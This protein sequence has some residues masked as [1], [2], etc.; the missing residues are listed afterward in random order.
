M[1][2][3]KSYQLES[4]INFLELHFLFRKFFHPRSFENF[5]FKF[6]KFK[7]NFAWQDDFESKS[8]QL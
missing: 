1:I 5:D 3:N 2:T 6:L 4:F 7:R 8:C